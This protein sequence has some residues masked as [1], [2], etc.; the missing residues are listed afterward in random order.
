MYGKKSA[1]NNSKRKPLYSLANNNNNDQESSIQ[2]ESFSKTSSSASSEIRTDP[3]F[4]EEEAEEDGESPPRNKIIKDMNNL[5]NGPKTT[6]AVME[7][8]FSPNQDDDKGRSCVSGDEDNYSK[9][10]IKLKSIRNKYRES[11]GN[12]ARQLIRRP[13]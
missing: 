6:K 11:A 13:S 12:I 7:V 4:I 2:S 1:H 8:K 5:S 10:P 9:K 3:S